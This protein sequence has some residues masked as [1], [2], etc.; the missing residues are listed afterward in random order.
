MYRKKSSLVFVLLFSF[1]LCTVHPAR[2]DETG[3]VHELDEIVVKS[4]GVID[5]KNDITMDSVGLA[6]SVDVI[7]AE[8]LKHMS[9]FDV[10]DIF[11]KVPG[12]S[13]F[14]YDQ[15]NIGFGIQLRGF[16]S[17]GAKDTAVFVDGVPMNLVQG[18]ING[19]V[20]IDWLIPEMIE[21]IEIIKGPFSALYGDF[22]LA[23]AINIITKKRDKSSLAVSGGTYGTYSGVATI[24]DMDWKIEPFVVLEGYNRDGYRDNGDYQRYQG[25][26]KFTKSLGNGLFSGRLQY[27]KRDWG[28][29]DYLPIDDVKSG[30]LD[31]T[32]TLDPTNEADDEVFNVVFNYEPQDGERG[33]RATLFFESF[34]NNQSFY[35]PPTPQMRFFDDRARMGYRVLYNFIPTDNFSLAVG[36]EARYDD[37]KYAFKFAENFSTIIAEIE[38]FNTEQWSS[39][40]FAQ[41]QYKPFEFLKLMGGVRYDYLDMDIDN[42]LDPDNSGE[43]DMNVF[44]PK[45]GMVVTP[46]ENLNFFANYGKGFRS[47]YVAEISP[48]GGVAN[49]DLGVAEIDSWDL[50]FNVLLGKTVYIGVDYYYTYLE[51][52]VTTNPETMMK[53]NLGESERTGVDAECRIYLP[54]NLEL[55]ATYGYVRGRLENPSEP[56]AVY[57]RGLPEDA[58]TLGFNWTRYLN[59]KQNIGFDAYYVRYGERPLDTKNEEQADPFH[60]YYA[61]L[62]YGFDKW[63]ISV[64]G[65]YTPDEYDS[66]WTYISGGTQYYLPSPEWQ[67]MAKI[68]YTF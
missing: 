1:F 6:A 45:I 8:D 9:I 26:G 62:N 13:V 2:S 34:E 58:L 47:P 61:K 30:L 52:E 35:F 11:R 54:H 12:V 24:S 10:T 43:S 40:V 18:K 31:P 50:G 27:V 4:Q 51:R 65:Q 49:F 23:G 63:D 59:E 15:G 56:G 39:G 32:D 42:V 44:S 16:R 25:F 37:V 48:V 5:K 20:D 19:W 46:Y 22:A 21:K 33:L 66:E 57:I 67:A 41:A 7:T 60:R 17:A 64:E 28:V 36:N 14:N 3:Q 53:E 55:F 29:A 68:K 38:K